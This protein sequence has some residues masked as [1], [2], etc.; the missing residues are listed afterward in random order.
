MPTV[1]GSRYSRQTPVLLQQPSRSCF[2]VRVGLPGIIVFDNATALTGEEFDLF[3]SDNGIKH[4]TSAIKHP[5]SNGFSERY[6][7]TFKETM[8]KMGVEKETLDTKLSRFLLSYRTTPHAT[9]GK[10]PGELLMNQKLKTRLDLVNPLSQDTIHTCVEHKQ[11]AQ[12]K[13]HDNLVPLRE[14][15]H[16]HPTVADDL[17]SSTELA[18]VPVQ[19]TVPKQIPE[20]LKEPDITVPEPSLEPKKTELPGF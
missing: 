1:S 20:E 5:A 7:R 6:V 11:L 3:M 13:Q 19:T 15:Q 2:S 14:F 9:T 8:K 10:T 4:I 18:Q 12:K 16:T 17:Q